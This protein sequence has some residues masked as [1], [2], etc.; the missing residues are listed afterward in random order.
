[1]ASFRLFVKRSSVRSLSFFH[2]FLLLLLSFKWSLYNIAPPTIKGIP[3][4]AI[5]AAPAVKRIFLLLYK[6]ALLYD[7]I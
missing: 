2:C 3:T 4:P 5:P 1:M 6:P 7:V